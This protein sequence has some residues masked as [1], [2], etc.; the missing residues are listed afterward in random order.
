MLDPSQRERVDHLAIAVVC[1][2]LT[3]I[4]LIASFVHALPVLL[5]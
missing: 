3:L 4:A 1:L 5:Q 2:V